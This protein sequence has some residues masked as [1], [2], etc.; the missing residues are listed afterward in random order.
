MNPN[1]DWTQRI[2]ATIDRLRE[3]ADNLPPESTTDSNP[4]T[5]KRPYSSPT[6][7]SARSVK[8]K[9]AYQRIQAK[10]GTR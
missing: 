1:D 9:N 7:A 8:A 5:V 4:R 2:R 3:A 6:G 10:K